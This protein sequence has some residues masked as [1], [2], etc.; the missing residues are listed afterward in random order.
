MRYALP[1]LSEAAASRVSAHVSRCSRTRGRS[2]GDA[3]G[4]EL[5][6]RHVATIAR[7]RELDL[8]GRDLALVEQLHLVAL[9]AAD[10]G[11]GD[12]VALRRAVLDLDVGAARHARHGA[13]QCL[14][15]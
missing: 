5:A 4:G 13:G 6:W 9:E 1:P 15:V 7:L 12:V 3:L 10:D 11:E 14:A 2:G 8:A